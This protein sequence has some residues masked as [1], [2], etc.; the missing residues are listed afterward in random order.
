[1]SEEATKPETNEDV[2]SDKIELPK[3]VQ[4]QLAELERLKSH[5]TKLLDETKTAKQK[6]AELEAAQQEAETKRQQE[7]G[8]FKELWEREQ[9]EKQEL[10]EKFSEFQARIQKQEIIATNTKLVS[11]LTRDT[12]RAELLAEKAQQFA[13]YTE[14]G[15][16]YEMGGVKVDSDKIVNH[17][18][19]KY[20]FLVDG[21]G[22]VGGGAT[23]AGRPSGASDTNQAAQ[24]AKQK[25]DLKGFLAAQLNK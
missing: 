24:A 8:E 6:A 21:T 12:S 5:H 11:E 18:K 4:E 15:V 14:D 19:E 25:G 13:K 17:L 20:P 3:E 9:R 22:A 10:S 1:M 23:G 7:K 2:Q 16:I